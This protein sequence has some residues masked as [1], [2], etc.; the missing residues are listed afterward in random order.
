MNTRR[1]FLLSALSAGVLGMP[2]EDLLAT[3]STSFSDQLPPL[4]AFL[5]GY[6]QLEDKEITSSSLGTQEPDWG[7]KQKAQ[8]I[9][10]ES[11]FKT[12][13][14]DVALY[15]RNI[16]QRQDR[17]DVA[18]YVRGWPVFYNPVI[19]EFFRATGLNPLD[20]DGKGDA[21]DWCAAFVNWCIARG[22]ST[23]GAIRKEELSRGTRSASSG[24]FRCW[25]NKAAETKDPK[26]GDIAVWAL[27]GTVNGCETGKGHVAFFEQFDGDSIVVIGGNQ[28]DPAVNQQAVMRKSERRTFYRKVHDQKVACNF[29]SFRTASFLR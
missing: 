3:T 18:S 16:G 17:P 25:P 15:F 9:I 27:E 2:R 21:T 7:R 26:R 1:V 6:A 13:P 28:L 12:T 11:P 19:I 22:T 10:S 5:S 8:A 29:H 20:R 23:D 14:Y 24:A 4:P